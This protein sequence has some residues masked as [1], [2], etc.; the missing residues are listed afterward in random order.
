MLVFIFCIFTSL[1]CVLIREKH[2]PTQRRKLKFI[3]F[4]PFSVVQLHKN[5]SPLFFFIGFKTHYNFLIS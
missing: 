3:A 2:F 4:L 1:L 5:P